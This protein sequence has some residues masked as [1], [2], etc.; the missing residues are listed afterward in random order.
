MSE[1]IKN[2][3][4]ICNVEKKFK[5]NEVLKKLNCTLF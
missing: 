4:E 5:K 3:L 2:K 1:E